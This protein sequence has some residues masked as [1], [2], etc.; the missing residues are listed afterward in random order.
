MQGK[1]DVNKKWHKKVRNSN[2][3]SSQY[4]IIDL[5]EAQISIV[6]QR[7]VLTTTCTNLLYGSRLKI[8]TP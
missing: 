5:A 7:L 4:F 2:P 1:S 3:N 6:G 8:H